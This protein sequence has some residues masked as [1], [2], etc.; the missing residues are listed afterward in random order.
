MDDALGAMRTN[1]SRAV[2]NA[3]RGLNIKLNNTKQ[4]ESVAQ[5]KML[6][7]PQKRK[8]YSFCRATT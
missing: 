2:D 3:L 6:Q 5:G 4:E 8:N 1:I 7:M